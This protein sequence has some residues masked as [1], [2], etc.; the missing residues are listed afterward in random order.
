MMGLEEA[1]TVSYADQTLFGSPQN[2]SLSKT[3]TVSFQTR[4]QR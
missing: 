3:L 2:T 1:W 4:W